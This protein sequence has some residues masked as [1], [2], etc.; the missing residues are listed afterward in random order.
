[1]DLPRG[2]R[3][4]QATGTDAAGMCCSTGQTSRSGDTAYSEIAL[5]TRHTRTS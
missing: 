3:H 1:M 4:I 5:C 2:Q